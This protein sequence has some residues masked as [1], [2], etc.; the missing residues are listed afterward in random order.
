MR[1]NGTAQ[2]PSIHDHLVQS[3]MI[4]ELG[5][6]SGICRDAHVCKVMIRP[7]TASMIHCDHSVSRRE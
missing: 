4:H 2:R 5:D 7:T 3:Q 6:V 1:R